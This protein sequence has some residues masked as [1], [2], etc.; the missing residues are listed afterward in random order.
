MDKLAELRAARAGKI[1]ALTA[2]VAKMA[3]DAYVET[4]ED[5]GAYDGLKAEIDAID[6]KIGALRKPTGSRRR[7]S[8]SRRDRGARPYP[9]AQYGR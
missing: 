3:A 2:L 9:R 7:W 1:D 4:A 6:K 5:T 8:R